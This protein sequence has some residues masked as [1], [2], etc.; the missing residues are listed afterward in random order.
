MEIEEELHQDS[1]EE[2]TQQY[3]ELESMEIDLPSLIS[4]A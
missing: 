2:N 1:E 4:N 3:M